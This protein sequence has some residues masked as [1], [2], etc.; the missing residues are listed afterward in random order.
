MVINIKIIL[1]LSVLFLFSC[2]KA[3]ER[4]CFKSKGEEAA[5]DV[6]FDKDIDSL[7]LYD[8]LFY[9]LIQGE[10]SKITLTGGENL[11]EHIEVISENRKLTVLN[12]NKCNF[13]RSFKN[14]IH[15][16][17]YVDS[18]RSIHYEGSGQLH[19]QDTLFSNELRLSITDGA[20][21]VNLTL[22]NGYTSAVITHGF[23]N[24][25]LK[26]KTT[27][28]FLH[29]NTNSYCDTRNFTAKNIT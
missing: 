14:K 5:L 3:H 6:S 18:V 8:D 29:C 7:F 12:K 26:G 20:G 1:L 2:K 17:I 21:D 4:V 22:K 11:L 13:L 25:T 28:A 27:Y 24:F 9:T 16:I 23:G 19:S 15:A 10:E